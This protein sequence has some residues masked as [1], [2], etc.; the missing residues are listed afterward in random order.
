LSFEF[1]FESQGWVKSWN[2]TGPH[3]FVLLKKGTNIEVFN[4]KIADLITKNSGDS[5]RS[6]FAAKFSENYLL[7]TFDHGSKV[8]GKSEYGRLFSLIAI[9]ILV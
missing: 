6:A 7:N 5:T 8:G 2:N 4:K 9:F 1:L 3:N